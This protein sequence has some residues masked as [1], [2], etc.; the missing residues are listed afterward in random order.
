MSVSLSRISIP[1]AQIDF[2][3]TSLAN[4]N[5]AL[6]PIG[7]SSVRM[8][9]PRDTTNL[10]QVFSIDQD[11]VF[12][13]FQFLLCHFFSTSDLIFE[14]R[15]KTFQGSGSKPHYMGFLNPPEIY[16]ARVQVQ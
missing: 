15:S 11:F 14:P 2:L 3:F 12:S 13:E 9:P 10:F 6:R 7:V 16:P 1:T 8:D 5:H 4:C